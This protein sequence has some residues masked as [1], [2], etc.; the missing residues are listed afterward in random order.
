MPR[1]L[2]DTTVLIDAL[3]GRPAADR[4]RRLRDAGTVPL[5]CAVNVEELWRGLRSEGV[6]DVR[7]LVEA[8]R[9]V[10]LGR[11]EGER[12]GAWR[13]EHAA[14]GI[15]LHQADCLIAA[16]AVTADATLATGNPADFPMH[17]VAVEHWPVGR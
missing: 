10:P 17:D 12:A 3:R 2:L 1:V 6:D 4:I 8:V 13:R 9:L 14:R 5:L 16:A 15:T 11:A 7:R